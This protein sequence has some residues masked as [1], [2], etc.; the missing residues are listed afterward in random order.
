M[1]DAYTPEDR[2][3]LLSIARRTL[4]AVTNGVLR[5][6]FDPAEYSPALRAER[7]CFVTLEIDHQLR[8]CTGTLV[9]RRC[10]ADEVSFT[11]VQTAFHDPRFQ[12]V[13]AAE[14]PHI[15]IEISVLTPPVPLQFDS[16]NELPNLIRPGIDGVTLQLGTR[17][18]TFLPQVWEKVSD[19]EQFLG[20][21]AHK[22]GLPTDGWRHPDIYAE[23]YQAVLIQEAAARA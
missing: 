1:T 6:Q 7:A 19:P 18:G 14:V 15:L 16:P 9:A 13:S 3:Q 17:R 20:L 2:V 22:M 5:P 8:G 21:L 23:I 4:T 10:L 11:T 12:P